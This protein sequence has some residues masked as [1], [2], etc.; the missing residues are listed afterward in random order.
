MISVLNRVNTTQYKMSNLAFSARRAINDPE[1]LPPLREFL[2]SQF[3]N[4]NTKISQRTL[5]INYY[6]WEG[7][8]NR[9]ATREQIPET[10][11]PKYINQLTE[12]E[13]LVNVS[14]Q[15]RQ[16]ILTRG[17]GWINLDNFLFKSK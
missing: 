8:Q 1:Y 3:S 13:I 17:P 4:E 14:R 5:Y 11:L 7:W 12:A 10:S 2:H 9:D 15:K 16:S 6:M